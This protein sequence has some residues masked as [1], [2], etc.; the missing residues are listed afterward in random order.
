[1]KY[2]PDCV[3]NMV[4]IVK[5]KFLEEKNVWNKRMLCPGIKYGKKN[6]PKYNLD[7]FLSKIYH[8]YAFLSKDF[9]GLLESSAQLT[10]IICR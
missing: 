8:S 2:S 7:M 1:M 10:L 3:I 5:Y 9:F 4:P 6:N